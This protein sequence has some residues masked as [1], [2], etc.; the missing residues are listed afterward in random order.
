VCVSQCTVCTSAHVSITIFFVAACTDSEGRTTAGLHPNGGPT[1]EMS[2]DHADYLDTPLTARGLEV[3]HDLQSQLEALQVDLV[4][5]SPLQRA[6]Q[7]ALEAFPHPPGGKVWVHEGIRE[8]MFGPAL[9]PQGNCTARCSITSKK[10]EWEGHRNSRD[11][12][13]T[14]RGLRPMALWP[15]RENNCDILPQLFYATPVF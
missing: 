1:G 14:S 6:L 4:V 8:V 7:T 13:A 10:K 5:S 15:S 2:R 9:T 12:A 3:A 11:G